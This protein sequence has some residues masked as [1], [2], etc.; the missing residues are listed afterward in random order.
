MVTWLRRMWRVILVFAA[1]V[2]GAAERRVQSEAELRDAVRALQAG[3]VLKLA[4][5]AYA[6]RLYVRGV[7][8]LTVC[9][10]DSSRPPIIQGGETG[11]QF[12]MCPGLVVRALEFRG[13]KINGLNIDDGGPANPPVSDVLL[14]GVRVR[15]VRPG[16]NYDG[17]KL[18]GLQH[19]MI[20]ECVIEGWGGQAIDLVGCDDVL[21]RDC[22]IIGRPSNG[23]AA[24][25]Q[26]KGG[27][28]RVVVERCRLVE[29]GQRPLN[30]GGSTGREFFRP[31][32][33]T[34]EARE[35]VV[36]DCRIEGGLCAV[37]FVGA[38]S[39]RFENNIVLFPRRWVFRILQ[40]T[41]DPQF[42]RCGNVRIADNRI[43]FRRADLRE[44]VNI[45]PGTAPET[46]RFERN[47]WFAE[48][49]PEDSLP[50]L[51]VPEHDGVYGRDPR[52][53]VPAAQERGRDEV[54]E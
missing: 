45:G 24:G 38:D 41:R 6:G 8:N 37:A 12:S 5:G 3:D 15:E 27:S 34:W 20:R 21:I 31:A 9:A 44:E 47:W 50:R 40:E 1:V 48:D 4:P 30:I 52:R 29:A 32:S 14:E 49:R 10:A 42:L 26:I 25:I 11:W 23:A 22:D 19:V 16:G 28:R 43:V 7:S 2:G 18:S 51:P 46:F 54:K 36:R 35:V 33:A 13:Q 17:I 53:E 39:A